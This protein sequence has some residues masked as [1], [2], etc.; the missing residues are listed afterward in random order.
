MDWSPPPLIAPWSPPALVVPAEPMPKAVT[1]TAKVAAYGWHVHRCA[2]GHEW[3]HNDAS[4]G[5]RAEHTCPKCGLVSWMPT[6]RNTRIVEVQ[7][8]P[9][10]KPLQVPPLYQLKNP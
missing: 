6:E 4:F 3:S 2:N 1:R 8:A 5:N 9:V 7:S 10:S